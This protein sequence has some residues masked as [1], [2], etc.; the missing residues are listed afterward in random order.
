MEL[1]GNEFYTKC[2]FD[3]NAI[4]RQKETLHYL[5]EQISTFI[6]RKPKLTFGKNMVAT[7]H[8]TAVTKMN[9][10]FLPGGANVHPLFNACSLGLLI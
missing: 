4:F 2:K 5:S 8:I 10:S 1:L 3:E 9:P 6:H 7:G